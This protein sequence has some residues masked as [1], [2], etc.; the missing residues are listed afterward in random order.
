[1]GLINYINGG[2]RLLPCEAGSVNFFIDPWGEVYPCNGM[3]ESKWKQS[4]GNIRSGK[5]FEDIWNSPEAE[6]VRR[7]VKNC[8]KNCWM[9]GTAS[10]VMKKHFHVPAKWVAENKLRS[11]V[12]KPVRLL[13]S[14]NNAIEAY[15]G[16]K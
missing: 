16:N 13:D 14:V 12:G 2:K 5:S 7:K 1:M 15:S 6:E 8:P 3:E 4:M 9:V 10:P 11:I